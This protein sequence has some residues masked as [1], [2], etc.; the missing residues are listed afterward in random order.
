M[1]LT[2]IEEV[3]LIVGVDFFKYVKDLHEQHELSVKEIS[4]LLNM[5][6]ATIHA[7]VKKFGYSFKRPVSYVL[8]S[9][10]IKEVCEK[11]KNGASANKLAK[12]YGCSNDS[13]LKVL[14]NSGI[15]IRATTDYHP[16]NSLA[17]SDTNCEKAAYYLG[18]LITDG[19]I[20]KSPGKTDR[21]GIELSAKDVCILEGLKEYVGNSSKIHRRERKDSRTGNIYSICSYSFTSLEIV[22][23]LKEFGLRPNKSLKET[24][25]EVFKNNRHFWRGVIEGDGHIRTGNGNY[26]LTLCGSKELCECFMSYC[27]TICPEYSPSLK[28]VKGDLYTV[29]LYS[30]KSTATVL[31]NLYGDAT[32]TL[33]RKYAVYIEVYNDIN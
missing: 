14:K 3:R 25:P 31:R 26:G 12:E 17:F 4:R 16:K 8:T 32:V 33:P 10:Q 24:V 20:T 7:R 27:K 22:K 5:E 21:V 13:I 2:P 19:Y 29:N 6:V 28:Q 23:R 9:A 18:W 1:A 30:K 15:E 11:Y